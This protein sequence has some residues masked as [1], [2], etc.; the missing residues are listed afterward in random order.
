M[1]P[2]VTVYSCITGNFDKAEL[3]IRRSGAL[4]ES[5]VSYVLFSDSATGTIKAKDTTWDVRPLQYTASLPC[6]RRRSR[7][8]K[9]NSHVLFPD[10]DFTLWIDGSQQ[11]KDGVQPYL[12]LIK[13]LLSSPLDL[14]TFKH[15]DRTCI[16]Q[17][18]SACIRLNKDNELLMRRQIARYKEY[19]YPPYSGLVETA[20]ILRR[21]SLA[22]S[23]FNKCWWQELKQNSLR[24]QLSFNYVA[25]KLK[26]PYG[27]IPGCRSDSAYFTFVG[28]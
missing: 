16:Y 11:F 21:K 7:W 19:G 6:N 22:V 9:L 10:S 24:D 14:H 5:N 15:P 25:W 28:H 20:C 2:T 17:E 12:Q 3:A 18:L 4:A 13:P 26:F 27:R 8:H 23:A 1:S